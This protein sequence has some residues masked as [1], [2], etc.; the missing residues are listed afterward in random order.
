[1]TVKLPINP[2]N[3]RNRKEDSPK[4]CARRRDSERNRRKAAAL[5]A[6]MTQEGYLLFSITIFSELFK[7]RKNLQRLVEKAFFDKLSGPGKNVRPTEKSLVQLGLQFSLP[8][9]VTGLASPRG[10]PRGG[11]GI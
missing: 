4:G 7:F 3:L 2:E 1:M 6:E 8:V 11:P 5:S 10:R 9:L